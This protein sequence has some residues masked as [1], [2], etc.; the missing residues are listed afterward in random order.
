MKMKSDWISVS[1]A[2]PKNDRDVLMAWEAEQSIMQ[3]KYWDGSDTSLSG[4]CVNKGSHYV[5]K[6]GVTHWMPVERA[7]YEIEAGSPTPPAQAEEE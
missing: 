2:L 7:L 1:D 6:I 3:G 4:F 5:G